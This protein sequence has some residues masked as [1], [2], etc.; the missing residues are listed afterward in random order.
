[1]QKTLPVLRPFEFIINHILS[2]IEADIYIYP[3]KEKSKLLI[4][5]LKGGEA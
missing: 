1:M 2:K 4:L 5:I 3:G